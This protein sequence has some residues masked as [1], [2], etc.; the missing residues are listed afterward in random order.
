MSY[1]KLTARRNYVAHAHAQC[2][3][4]AVKQVTPWL[5]IS[6]TLEL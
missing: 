6:Y 2:L 4:L 3:F 5:F 1:V